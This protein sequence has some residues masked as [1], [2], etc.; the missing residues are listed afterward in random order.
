M[1]IDL[2]DHDICYDQFI[3]DCFDIFHYCYIGIF[4]QQKHIHYNDFGDGYIFYYMEIIEN[5]K[6]LYMRCKIRLCTDDPL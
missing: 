1:C 4:D 5:G 6:I 3:C 2:R